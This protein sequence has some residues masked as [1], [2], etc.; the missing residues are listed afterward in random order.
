M[1]QDVGEL[2]RIA[3]PPE[4]KILSDAAKQRV[5]AARKAQAYYDGDFWWYLLEEEAAWEGKSLFERQAVDYFTDNRRETDYVP[6]KLEFG[7]PKFFIDEIA[8]WMFENPVSLKTADKAV[9]DELTTIHRA[10][11]L[12]EKLLQSGVEGCLTGGV[13][14]KV[15]YVPGRGVRMI[16]RPSRECFPVMDHDD[17]DL[18]EKVHFAAFLDDEVHVWRQTFELVDG[19]CHVR[20]EIFKIDELSKRN[21]MP[22]KVIKDEDLYSGSN[23]IDFIPVVLIPNEPNLGEVWG[24]SDL[25]PLYTM[26]NEIC[27]KM[28]DVADALKFELFPVTI[29]K[30]V[31]KS[32]VEDFEIS[33]GAVW[34]LMDGDSDHQASADKLESTLGNMDALK[35][36]VDQL[37]EAMHQF[38][39][40]P[41]V[42]RDK[43]D[44]AGNISGVALKLMFTSI[45]SKCNRKLM[46]WKPRLEQAYEYALQ[47]AS[48]YEGFKF[49]REAFD[50][51]VQT[52]PRIPQ[53][54]LEQLEIQAKKIE[55]LV[56]K[57]VS[58]MQELGVE[59]PEEELMAI[60]EERKMIDNALS[61]DIYADVIDKEAQGGGTTGDE[62]EGEG[63]PPGDEED[64]ET[65]EGPPRP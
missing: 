4:L 63:L 51:E 8:S 17:I 19:V 44:T 53:N 62:S 54:E 1:I 36:Y 5:L 24:E 64:R 60:L 40:I 43:I 29:L 7:Y 18:T 31:L 49:D 52:T 58:V 32:A 37:K 25:N 11:M 50:L 57:V 55:M 2:A 45:V 26:V 35:Q 65:S 28:S 34:T 38:S 23:P 48:V 10:N 59:E 20:E 3:Y 41:N 12:D 27:R 33:P 13:A 42:T 6:S 16:F 15:L 22:E 9:Y 61:A 46:Y 30:N 21:P 39:G 14:V 56:V 47:T